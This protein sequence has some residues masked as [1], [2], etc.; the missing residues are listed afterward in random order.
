MANAISIVVVILV[1]LLTGFR[2]GA[3][4]LEW[5]AAAGILRLFTVALTWWAVIAGLS[6]KTVA[7]A[8]AFS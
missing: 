4:V 2:F 8:S 5:L 1:A 7:G 6:V 3:G